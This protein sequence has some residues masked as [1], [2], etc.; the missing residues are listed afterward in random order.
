MP[1]SIAAPSQPPL[2]QGIVPLAPEGD[3]AA[4]KAWSA[5]VDAGRIGV[6]AP[7]AG[8]GEYGLASLARILAGRAA[9]G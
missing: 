2:A 1:R 4:T 9:R 6:I 5:H 8:P 3:I 7:L